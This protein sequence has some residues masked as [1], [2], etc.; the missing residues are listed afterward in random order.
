MNTMM[1]SAAV[2][3]LL[4]LAGTASFAASGFGVQDVVPE[5]DSITID[6]VVADA[7]GMVV[8]YNYEG[9][10]IGEMLGSAPV[11]AGAN[12]DVVVNLGSDPLGPRITALL[13]EGEMMDD[14]MT[15]VARTNFDVGM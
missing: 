5:D 6:L 1:K 12:E 2:A 7:D 4:G 11:S 3:A 13:F 10:M 8:V 14:P 15:A 9:G